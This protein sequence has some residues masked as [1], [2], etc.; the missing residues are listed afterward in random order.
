MVLLLAHAAAKVIEYWE[1]RKRI[2]RCADWKLQETA[3]LPRVFDPELAYGCC[4]QSE[5]AA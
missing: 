3:P 4:E 5:N 1:F 2:C